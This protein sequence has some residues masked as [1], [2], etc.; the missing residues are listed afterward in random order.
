MVE[1]A[2][3]LPDT[4]NATSHHFD[5]TFTQISLLEVSLEGWH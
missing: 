4:G 5:G 1:F 3:L 2:Y